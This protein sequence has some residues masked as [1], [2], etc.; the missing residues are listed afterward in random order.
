MNFQLTSNKNTKL[1]AFWRRHP[2]VCFSGCCFFLFFLFVILVSALQ[3]LTINYNLSMIPYQQQLINPDTM[4]YEDIKVYSYNG[5][6]AYNFYTC[7]TQKTSSNTFGNSFNTYIPSSQNA[8]FA[9]SM[10]QWDTVHYNFSLNNNIWFYIVEGE[11]DFN[12][13]VLD[14]GAYNGNYRF[15]QYTTYR[16]ATWTVNQKKKIQ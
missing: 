13:L 16:S 10:D 3:P 1:G 7:P 12:N 11:T 14:G 8:Y 2:K 9:V 15:R 6:Q 5:I 4:W